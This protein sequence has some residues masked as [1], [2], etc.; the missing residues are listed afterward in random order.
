VMDPSN[1]QVFGGTDAKWV[2]LPRPTKGISIAV[3]AL[4][5]PGTG[6]IGPEALSSSLPPVRNGEVTEAPA[7]YS[8]ERWDKV[9]YKPYLKKSYSALQSVFREMTS[10]PIPPPSN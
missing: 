2:P 7:V 3:F 8:W 4:R 1:L 10:T 5:A 9:E 6:T